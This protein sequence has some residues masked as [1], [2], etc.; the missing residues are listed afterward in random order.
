MYKMK[1]K[2]EDARK[3]ALEFNHSLEKDLELA[4]KLIV[5]AAQKGCSG[6]SLSDTR[7]EHWDDIAK[8]LKK[9]GYCVDLS[10]NKL[11]FNVYWDED[12]YRHF[13]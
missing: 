6:C 7:V 3:D 4:E 9:L 13:S 2:A 5:Q 8:E 10:K 11:T 1:Y 12:L